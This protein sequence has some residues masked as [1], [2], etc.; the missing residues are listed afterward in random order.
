MPT[1]GPSDTELALLAPGEHVLNKEAV[2]IAGRETLD[3]LN[4]KA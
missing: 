3:N 4:A 2:S 1:P